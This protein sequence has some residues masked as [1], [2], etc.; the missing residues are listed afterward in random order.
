L[1]LGYLGN[2][3]VGPW[4]LAHHVLLLMTA[5]LYTAP[6]INGRTEA[7]NCNNQNS[8]LFDKMSINNQWRDTCVDD[9]IKRSFVPLRPC[10]ERH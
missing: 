6:G 7:R 4:V 8:L 1:T 3:W 9:K 10:I 5:D 2:D